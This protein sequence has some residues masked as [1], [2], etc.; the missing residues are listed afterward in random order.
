[1]KVLLYF[2]FV[3]FFAVGYQS[4]AKV[5]DPCACPQLSCDKECELEENV[6]FYSEKC[7]SGKKVRSCARPTCIKKDPY[8]AMC[9]KKNSQAASNKKP[10]R[11]LATSEPKPKVPV[12]KKVGIIEGLVGSSWKLKEQNKVK[13]KLGDIVNETETVLT[14][15]KSS[16]E[17]RFDDGNLITLSENSKVKL[18]EV[19]FSDDDTQRS[20][21]LHL[22]KGKIRS[23]VTKKYKGA[24]KKFRISTKSAV[25]GVR[26]TDFVVELIDNKTRDER[27]TR[28]STLEGA[29]ELGGESR[30][31]KAL[32]GRGE[33]ADYVEKDYSNHSESDD[34]LRKAYLTSVRKMSAK[35]QRSLDKGTRLSARRGLASQKLNSLCQKP[36]A[37]FNQCSWKCVNNPSGEKTCRTDIP[38][39][40]CVRSVCK[41]DGSWQDM[42][43]MPA[44]YGHYCLPDKVVV[45][46]CDY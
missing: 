15:K 2:S 39:V 35:E 29:V 19:V 22:L 40:N 45:D 33:T 37:D 31:E 44:S 4:K 36:R 28:V 3:A 26:G 30:F 20:A 24:S 13:L 9:L 8:P 11:K 5:T 41:A 27:I 16:L 14:D 38:N 23:K 34:F 42:T 17:I 7:D 18:S 25:A 1:M 12:K 6:T 43:R 21:L 32:I 10:N 46:S